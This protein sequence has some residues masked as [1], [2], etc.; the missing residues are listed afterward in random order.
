MENKVKEENKKL[1]GVVIEPPYTREQIRTALMK[2]FDKQGI[3][4]K[5]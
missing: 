4:I 5:K 1:E 2:M 3:K